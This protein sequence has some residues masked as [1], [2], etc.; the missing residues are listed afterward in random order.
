LL[1]VSEEYTGGL[2]V[3]EVRPG[4]PADRE[5]IIVGD[6]IVGILKWRTPTVSALQWVLR[7]EEFNSAT[8]AK[9]YV[10]RNNTTYWIAMNMNKSKVR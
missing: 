10:V 5:G 6:V 1:R 9:F 3:L 4:S 8:S 7:N 2:K